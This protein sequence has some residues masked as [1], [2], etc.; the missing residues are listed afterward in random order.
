MAVPETT[1]PV[2]KGEGDIPDKI[3]DKTKT[4]PKETVVFPPCD[5]CGGSGTIPVTSMAEKRRLEHY[6][7]GKEHGCE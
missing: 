4:P 7:K 6:T 5:K 3:M 2:C 1:C